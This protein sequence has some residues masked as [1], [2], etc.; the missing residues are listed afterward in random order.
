MECTI[1]LTSADEETGSESWSK[2][3]MSSQ[4]RTDEDSIWTSAVC[5]QNRYSYICTKLLICCQEGLL[6][7][8]IPQIIH[9][10]MKLRW[11]EYLT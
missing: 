4:H 5:L 3:P 2:L 6:P 9:Y 8:F 1:I 7:V 10:E 11:A